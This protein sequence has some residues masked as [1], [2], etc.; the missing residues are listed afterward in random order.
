MIDRDQILDA[1]DAFAATRPR[2]EFGNY[3]NHSAYR[4]EVRGITRDLH[5][6]RILLAA[7]RRSSITGAQL[8]EAFRGKRLQWN[9]AGLNYTTGQYYPVEY[10]PAVCSVAVS[11]LWAHY[12]ADT[13]GDNLGDK[14]RATARRALPR[15]ISNRWFS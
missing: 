12:A 1:L 11:A 5:H 13:S 14:I 3:G 10:R 8:V 6:A 15:A 9:G 2:L 4:Q 7:V